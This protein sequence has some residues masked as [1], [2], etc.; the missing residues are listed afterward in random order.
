MPKKN[1]QDFKEKYTYVHVGTLV[2][3]R[4]RYIFTAVFY[5]GTAFYHTKNSH[6]DITFSKLVKMIIVVDKSYTL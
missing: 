5:R 1:N 4:I 3:M 6:N 2:S